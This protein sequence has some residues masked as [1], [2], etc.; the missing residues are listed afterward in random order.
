[1]SLLIL[2]KRPRQKTSQAAGSRQEWL[3]GS[4]I[5]RRHQAGSQRRTEKVQTLTCQHRK[6]QLKA[7]F[8]YAFENLFVLAFSA[9]I[10]QRQ[11]FV[12]R[13]DLPWDSG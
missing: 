8:Y 6:A 12:E 11:L 13:Y 10:I 4:R 7:F 2:K 5:G 9:F 3:F 1:V